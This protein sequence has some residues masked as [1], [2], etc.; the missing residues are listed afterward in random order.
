MNI[1]VRSQFTALANSMGVNPDAAADW[2]RQHRSQEALSAV[3]GH[4]LGRDLRSWA[5]LI[6]AYQQSGGR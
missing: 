2:I 1:G 3:R 5:P 4:V 6:K